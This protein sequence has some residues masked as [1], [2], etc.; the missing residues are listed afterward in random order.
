MNIIC[1]LK[2][3]S[4][5]N[6]ICSRCGKEK[7]DWEVIST[8]TVRTACVSDREYCIACGAC[9]NWQ[10]PQTTIRYLR[11]KNCNDRKTISE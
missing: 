4:F 6:C 2:G 5:V 1:L 3:H 9:P 10:H 11:C 8:E 7:H